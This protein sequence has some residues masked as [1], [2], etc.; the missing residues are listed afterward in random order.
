MRR[1]ILSV[2]AG[3]LCCAISG[4]QLR[5]DGSKVLIQQMQTT[6]KPAMIIAGNEGCVYCRQI[7]QELAGN[8]GLQPLVQQFFIV[9][10]DTDSADWPA[11]QQA[12]QFNSEGIP[13]VFVVRADG[14]LIY[15][16]SGKPRDMGAFLEEQLVSAGAIL[17]ADK[18]QTVQKAAR[19]A[20]AAFKRRKFALAIQI[21]N[22]HGATGSFASAALSL[23][24]MRDELHAQAVEGA[25]SAEARITNNKQPAQAAIDLVALRTE[26]AELPPA[27]EQIDAVWTKLNDSDEHKDLMQHAEQ[28]AQA[29]QHQKEKKWN[30]ALLIYREIA[31]AAPDSAAGNY[32]QDQV[33]AVE[34]RL[35]AKPGTATADAGDPESDEASTTEADPSGTSTGEA[36]PDEAPAGDPKKAAS[37][38]KLAKVFQKKDAAKARDYLEK[39]IAAAPQ[40]PEAEEAQK[41]LD[42]L[43]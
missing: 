6:G 16:K 24:A 8:A 42:A 1:F 32:S 26:F 2:L 38:L 13:A 39:A 43:N 10:V 31:K 9:K 23:A 41:L 37:F 35:A 34:R 18:L 27:K 25:T 14:K 22:E 17:D 7:A 21:V 19:D 20:Q 40:S 11:L 36:A 15:S 29:A 3:L 30:E 33:K 12:F 28:L 5:A 4:S